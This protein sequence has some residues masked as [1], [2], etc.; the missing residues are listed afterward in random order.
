VA[1]SIP[2][3]GTR[4]QVGMWCEKQPHATLDFPFGEETAVYKIGGKM[5]ALASVVGDPPRLTL[6]VIP[7]EGVALRAQYSCV[8]E[9]YY[10]NKQHWITVDLIEEIP[11]AAVRE[12]INDSYRIVLSSLPKKVRTA[13]VGS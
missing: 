12:L 1:S 6:K 2:K 5:F 4:K 7:E 9:G 3:A 10:M 8:R 13:L 11:A